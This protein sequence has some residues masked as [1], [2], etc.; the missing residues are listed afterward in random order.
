MSENFLQ[1]CQENGPP[2]E[3]GCNR[4]SQRTRQQNK[5]GDRKGELKSI[6]SPEIPDWSKTSDVTW[7]PFG[8]DLSKYCAHEDK[9]GTDESPQEL[10][11]KTTEK[12]SFTLPRPGVK[13]W[14]LNRQRSA[15]ASQPQTNPPF[16]C[17]NLLPT[18]LCGSSCVAP[19]ARVSG[20][21]CCTRY[22][23][24]QAPTCHG[25]CHPVRSCPQRWLPGGRPG[26]HSA[27][28]T[29]W[30]P[31]STAGEEEVQGVRN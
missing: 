27:G 26:A 13:S 1:N 7:P 23:C 18:H 28:S 6:D 9:T 14:P 8:G 17:S 11:W 2:A 16:P 31:W 20:T 19:P 5:R 10:P 25:V 12:R 4:Q 3:K 21:P 24:G 30:S 15:S 22:T 29:A